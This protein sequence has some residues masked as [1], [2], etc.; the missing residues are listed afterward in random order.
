MRERKRDMEV[1]IGKKGCGSDNSFLS[2]EY[3]TN[4]QKWEQPT[5]QLLTTE[6]DVLR[7]PCWRAIE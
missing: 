2:P 5:S 4:T 6:R 7:Q 3:D 1:S